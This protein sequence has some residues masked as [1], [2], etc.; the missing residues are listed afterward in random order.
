MDIPDSEL[1]LLE[2]V[3]AAKDSGNRLT[4]RDLAAATGL[5]LGMTNALVKKM[6]ERGWLSLM[7]LSA[8][9]F[10]YALTPEGVSE[11]AR[12]SVGYFR[13]ASRSASLY[14]DHVEAFVLGAKRRGAESLVLVGPS[15]A[16]FVI[17]YAC[18]RHGL[19]FLKS[20]DLAR[21]GAF[22]RRPGVALVWG[23]RLSHPEGAEAALGVTAAA[24]ILDLSRVGKE[25]VL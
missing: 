5:S 6:A 3:H 4:Q 7:R 23:E 1:A 19:T 2:A 18:E 13:Q 22:A 25:G 24:A 10:R 20:S 21:A 14:R 11:V 9:S 12:R 15:E 16:D 17:E 8:K